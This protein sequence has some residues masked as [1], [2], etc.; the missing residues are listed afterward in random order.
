MQKSYMLLFFCKWPNM[1]LIISYISEWYIHPCVLLANHCGSI[2]VILLGHTTQHAWFNRQVIGCRENLKMLL[3]YCRDKQHP[4]WHKCD[5]NNVFQLPEKLEE[6]H[7]CTSLNPLK[8]YSA[9]HTDITKWSITLWVFD[10]DHLGKGVCIST[11]MN[12]S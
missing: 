2:I 11:K 12:M 9:K 3:G 5:T 10:I 6:S 4:L 1:C 7:V 8:F